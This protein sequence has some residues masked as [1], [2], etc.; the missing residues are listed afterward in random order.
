MTISMNITIAD[1]DST[2]WS[3]DLCD[4][5]PLQCIGIEMTSTCNL[6]CVYCSKSDPEHNA[7]PGRDMHMEPDVSQ[8]VA[9]VTEQ[10][11]PEIVA[12]AGTGETTGMPNWVERCRT[13][14]HSGRPALNL[15]SNFARIFTDEE[16]EYLAS[17]HFL[18]VSIDTSDA[19]LLKAMRRKVNLH[20]IVYNI[21]RV[22]AAATAKNRPEPEISIH[23]VLTNKS[24]GKLMDLI[25][26]CHAMGLKVFRFL[27]LEETYHSKEAGLFSILNC[28]PDQQT[29]F[30][31]EIKKVR[32]FSAKH[33]IEVVMAEALDNFLKREKTIASP[34][35]SRACLQPWETLYVGADGTTY[36]C[37]ALQSPVGT[38]DD[39]LQ[40]TVPNRLREH[41]RRMLTGNLPEICVNCSIGRVCEP[42]ELQQ[43]VAQKLYQAGS[44]KL[45]ENRTHHTRPDYYASAENALNISTSLPAIISYI[46]DVNLGDECGTLSE[47]NATTIF[48]HPGLNTPTSFYFL[49]TT[50][51]KIRHCASVKLRAFIS[52]KVSQ[53][54]IARGAAVVR[55]SICNGNELCA[56]SI[57]RAGEP[58]E[59]AINVETE[60]RGWRIEVENFNGP[61]TDWLLISFEEIFDT[62]AAMQAPTPAILWLAVNHDGASALDQPRRVPI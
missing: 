36:P 16:I 7:Q 42:F 33:G 14:D 39:Y 25:H 13:F 11:K 30:A 52:P 32:E 27:D 5:M 4:S 9:V 58:L 49:A 37:C 29:A 20:T 51:L 62:P 12:L 10:L 55:V 18:Q 22:K 38:I 53:E 6:R 44:V 56:Q 43:F 61:D 1:P 40:G 31:E 3:I 45:I 57:V 59:F 2:L 47:E 41:R 48:V 19:E 28:T 8:K 26:L 54:A 34:G 24:I 17:L 35:L 15:N 60:D 21:I 23:C 50:Y 46:K